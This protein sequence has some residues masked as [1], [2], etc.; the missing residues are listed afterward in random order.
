MK[1]SMMVIELADGV[2][3]LVICRYSNSNLIRIVWR[4]HSPFRLEDQ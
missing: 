2:R 4:P 3:D 1:I